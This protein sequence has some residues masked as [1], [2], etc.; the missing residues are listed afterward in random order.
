M[1]KGNHSSQLTDLAEIADVKLT[2]QHF[3]HS[4]K[5]NPITFLYAL[6]Y[7]DTYWSLQTNANIILVKDF[8]FEGSNEGQLSAA[9][10]QIL[11]FPIPPPSTH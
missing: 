4:H 1:Q 6:A 10:R 11:S 3:N 9:T 8:A 2:D 7:T 5:Q